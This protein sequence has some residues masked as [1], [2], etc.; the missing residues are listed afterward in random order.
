MNEAEPSPDVVIVVHEPD[1]SP[2][3]Y[4][5]FKDEMDQKISDDMAETWREIITEELGG[6]G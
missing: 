1:D 3:G 5:N 6:E 2:T 4:R